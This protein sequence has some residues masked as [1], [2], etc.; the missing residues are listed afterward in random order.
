M[1]LGN[2]IVFIGD[3]ITEWGRGE[4]TEGIGTSYVR[5][6]HDYFRTI[7]PEQ[8]PA[9][10]NRGVGGDRITDIAA[11]WQEDVIALNPDVI[12]VSVGINDVWRQLDNPN[13]EQ[14]SPKRFEQIYHD[15]IVE[16]KQEIGADI[17]LMEP[18][19]IEEN[20]HSEG[21]QKLIPY[22][23]IVNKIAKQHETFVVP[24]HQAFIKYLESNSGYPLTTDGVHM[25][26]AGNMLMAQTWLKTMEPLIE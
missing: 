19:L 23:E 1:K 7:Y 4:D 8:C 2:R 6:I 17:I 20:I 21:N 3:S 26:S 13:I 9:I 22:I 15:L 24:T 25:N 10:I 12:T 18:T 16:V 5:L 11:R 14:V